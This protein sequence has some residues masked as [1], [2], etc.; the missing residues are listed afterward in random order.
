MEAVKNRGWALRYVDVNMQTPKI[1]KAAVMEYSG[2]LKYVNKKNTELC[3]IAVKNYGR[4][5]EYVPAKLQTEKMCLIAVEQEG[6]NLEWVNNQTDRICIAALEN[7]PGALSYIK[8][9]SYNIYLVAAKNSYKHYTMEQI[10]P[11]FQTDELCREALNK[12]GDSIKSINRKIKK[13]WMEVLALQQNGKSLRFIPM[14]KRTY[15]YCK[16]AVAS[17]GL[18]LQYVP[19]KFKTEEICNIALE[20]NG[21][22]LK[23][24]RN[25]KIDY[26]E[27]AIK[28]NNRAYCFSKYKTKLSYFEDSNGPLD[29]VCGI[30]YEKEGGSNWCKLRSCSHHYHIDCISEWFNKKNCP[31]C[32]YCR[33]K[34]I[35]KVIFVL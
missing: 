6:F 25:Q 13:P 10:P 17:N 26:C 20:K 23:Y 19:E 11:E 16:M 12:E 21:M 27:R 24:I 28:Q 31:N 18:A 33:T 22:A 14:H 15:D 3:F 9:K 2:A 30:C 32:P 35:P 4:T 29:D 5:L 34:T 1:C 7:D 8:N